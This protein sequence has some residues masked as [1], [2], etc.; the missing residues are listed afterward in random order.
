[1]RALL[2]LLIF[3]LIVITINLM[4]YPAD[5]KNAVYLFGIYTLIVSYP[6]VFKVTFRA[7]EKMN[8]ED[9]MKFMND[10]PV[11]VDINGNV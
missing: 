7:F 5:T 1:M 10:K 9:L 3:A 4:S 6:A 2:S 11:L 8:L